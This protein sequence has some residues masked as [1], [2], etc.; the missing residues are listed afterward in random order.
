[1]VFLGLAGISFG[2]DG[3]SLRPDLAA[4]E[5]LSKETGVGVNAQ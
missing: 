4:S 1:M 2:A 3:K 5:A